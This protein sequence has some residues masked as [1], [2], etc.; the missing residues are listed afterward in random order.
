MSKL[1]CTLWLTGLSASGKSSLAEALA[2]ALLADGV[3]C[4]VLDG[5]VIRQQLSRDLG[6]SREDRRENI[7]RVSSL[8]RELNDAG[9]LAIAAL[10]SPYREDRELA[11]NNIGHAQ[12]IEVHMATPLE[13]CEARDPKGL[14]RLARRGDVSCFTGISAPYEKPLT[15]DLSLNTAL[16]SQNECFNLTMNLLVERLLD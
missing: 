6:F 16:Q 12:F 4:E 15:P 2:K 14:Y 7:R 3:L 8:C 9:T 13:V 11:R 10:I 1:A 5:D